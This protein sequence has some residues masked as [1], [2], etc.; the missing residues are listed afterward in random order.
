MS[1]HD[2]RRKAGLSQARFATIM[3]TT[4]PRISDF[5]TGRRQLTG[6]HR[7]LVK[8]INILIDH[9]LLDLLTTGEKVKQ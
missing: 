2:T 1:I 4:Q 6:A 7:Q 3:G 5:E 9:G 8:A